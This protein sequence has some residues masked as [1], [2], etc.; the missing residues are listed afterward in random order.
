MIKYSE[1]IIQ[2]HGHSSL[3]KCSALYTTGLLYFHRTGNG[4]VLSLSPQIWIMSG[5]MANYA[6]NKWYNFLAQCRFIGPPSYICSVVGWNEVIWC[7]IVK[8]TYMHTYI[9]VCVTRWIYPYDF[10]SQSFQPVLS[11]KKRMILIIQILEPDHPRIKSGSA[12]Y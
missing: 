11:R 4:G 10:P 6:I 8:W 2:G 7:I 12:T 1:Y 5:T 3:I 9:R